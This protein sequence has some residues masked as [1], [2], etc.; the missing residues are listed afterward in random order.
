MDKQLIEDIIESIF[1]AMPVM[2]RRML[3]FV[4]NHI[5]QGLTHSHFAIL[6][7]LNRTDALAVS[8]IGK[9]LW[10]SKPQMTAMIDKL[11]DLQYVVR[12]PDIK[13]RRVI[14]IS[15]T[16]EGE[17]FLIQARAIIK[18]NL[19]E[20]VSHLSLEDLELLAQSLKNI[21]NIG[22]KLE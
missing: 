6:G 21:T 4:D 19:A 12:T 9:R 13:D 1:A 3:S 16:E 2:Q 15:L 17:K 11:V 14:H 10:I 22:S 18:K 8:E 20:K 5:S 7:M